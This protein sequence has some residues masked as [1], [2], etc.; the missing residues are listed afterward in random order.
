MHVT[1]RGNGRQLIFIDPASRERLLRLT[2]VAL[3][4]GGHL[5]HAFCL[6]DNH[7]HFLVEVGIGALGKMM[8]EITHRYA[9]YLHR[10]RGTDGHL[11]Q[12]RFH[13]RVCRN[14]AHLLNVLRYIHRNPVKH[15][16]VA[17]VDDWPWSSHWAYLGEKSS[18]VETKR[19]L[20]FFRGSRDPV[21]AYK[22]FMG[23][24]AEAKWPH[25]RRNRRIRAQAPVP[26]KPTRGW[27]P[28]VPEEL[29]RFAARHGI[30]LDEVVGKSRLPALSGL[31]RKFAQECL[32]GG[33]SLSEIGH[34]LRRSK[35]AIHR[36]TQG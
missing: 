7:F 20:S 18:L 14:D 21:E 8:K 25:G 13:S 19:L 36:M 12:D 16:A 24:K 22:A 23:A 5:L 29:G 27:L 28:P 4:R 31:R 6:M 26:P 33:Y 10:R 11:F 15:G 34:A 32:D 1:A 2:L 17:S 30:P 9:Q 35:Q 3:R